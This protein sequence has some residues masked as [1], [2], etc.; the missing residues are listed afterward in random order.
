MKDPALALTG[1]RKSFS[2]VQVVHGVDL[3][4]HEP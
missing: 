3:D 2:D 4:L 1:I